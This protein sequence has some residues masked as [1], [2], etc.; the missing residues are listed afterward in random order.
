MTKRIY[1][2]LQL[3]LLK[4]SSTSSTEKVKKKD[5]FNADNGKI[6]VLSV[7]N[8]F[9]LYIW[10]VFAQMCAGQCLDINDFSVN[11]ILEKYCNF[12]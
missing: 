1:M 7:P 6:K 11:T 12:Y 5:K 3:T 2:K 10:S 4:L 9:S 8:K